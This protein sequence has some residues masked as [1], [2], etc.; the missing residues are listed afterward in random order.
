MFADII[1]CE[2]LVFA[3]ILFVYCIYNN[4]NILLGCFLRTKKCTN[5]VTV[6]FPVIHRGET[7]L[8]IS[9]T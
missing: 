1:N 8:G 3:N 7:L 9:Y 6:M 5:F 4:V 2:N